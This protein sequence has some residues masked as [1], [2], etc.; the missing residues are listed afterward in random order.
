MHSNTKLGNNDN[1]AVYTAEE[2]VLSGAA[3]TRPQDIC[4]KYPEKCTDLT[5]APDDCNTGCCMKITKVD[6]SECQNNVDDDD[7]NGRPKGWKIESS[8]S[9]N[10]A[11]GRVTHVIRV[12][13]FTCAPLKVKIRILGTARNYPVI[14]KNS[15][16]L[17]PPFGGNDYIYEAEIVPPHTLNFLNFETLQRG[18]T[19][20]VI[21]EE[22]PGVPLDA[23]STLTS[24]D[25]P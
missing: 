11:I 3:S 19:M 17:V 15:G 4:T 13:N 7:C 21:P 1:G 10:E 2:A 14:S 18:K 23:D 24:T 12:W 16:T 5:V 8:S 25:V 20:T 9:W 22:I 6:E